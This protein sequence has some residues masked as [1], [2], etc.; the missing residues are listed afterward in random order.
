[1]S[2]RLN[3]A[4]F[5]SSLVSAYWNG[6]ATY[7]RGI[8]RALAARGH[9][10][11]F[12]EPD[13]YDRQSHRDIDDPAWAR[14]VVY[15]GTDEGEALKMV[16]VASQQADV[17]VKASGV[18]VF[19]ELLEAAVIAERRPGRAAIFWDVD[20][21]ATLDRMRSHPHEPFRVLV[22][23]YDF[24]L[25]YGGGDPVVSAYGRFGARRCVPIYN[26]VDP[27]TH[28]R[29]PFD[30]KFAG[31][32]A[33]LGNRLPDRE[34][35]VDEFFFGPARALAK[36]RFLLG[37]SGWAD[38]PMPASVEYLG[39][40]YTKDHNALN[41]SALAVLN[42]ARDS[43]AEVGFSPATRVFEAAGAGA[44]MITDAWKGIERFLEPEREVLVAT[45]GEQVAHHLENLTP[46]RARAVGEAAR[47]RILAHH[48]YGHRARDVE[49]LLVGRDDRALVRAE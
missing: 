45:H 2:A 8:I 23:Q 43:M 25:T 34:A 36:K 14:V 26:A 9:A 27:E 29:V 39:H 44:C 33:F 17:V 47:A 48:T 21:P 7:Y 46:E 20:A 19:D 1:V 38:K 11:T 32:L 31:D 3:I 16:R 42:I 4:F 24:V 49:A 41:S 37:G 5:G 10:V 40:V 12:Y 15:S 28:H 6:A 13:A 30:S 35:R 18:G 22:P